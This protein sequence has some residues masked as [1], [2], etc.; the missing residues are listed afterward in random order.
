MMGT[1]AEPLRVVCL[2]PDATIAAGVAAMFASIPDFP[3]ATRTV[4]YDEGLHDMREP[5]LAVVVLEDDPTSGIAVIERVRRDARG[6]Y[7]VAVSADDDAETLVRAMRAG[8]H[9]HLSLPL[10]QQELFK[11]CIKVVERRRGHESDGGRHGELWVAYGPK[12]GVGVTTL[13]V[14]LALALHAAQRDVAVVDL[15]VYSG[16]AAF[17]LDVKPSCTLR[18]VAASEH[19][20]PVFVRGAMGR[21]GS[22]LPILAA[23]A[24]GREES[25]ELSAE[26]TLMILELVTAMHEITV[27]DTP[28][29]PSAATRAALGAADRVLLVTDLTVPALRGC[30]RTLDWLRGE[31]VDP[32]STVDVIVNRHDGRSSAEVSPKEASRTLGLP[33]R[34]LLPRDDAAAVGAVNAGKPLSEVRPGGVLERAIA[35]LAT[36]GAPQ[37]EASL[38]RPGFLRLFAS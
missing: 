28:G 10:S 6:A 13:V 1:V 8:A 26:R 15:D 17:F 4:G 29:I 22:G 7:V 37:A 31:G 38:R 27:V 9:E 25:I 18:Q 32:A 14:N 12:G 35:A 3:L 33:L 21:H 5:D 16:D 11:T 30:V 36:P 2:S 24:A 23:S 19:L 34:A 20:D